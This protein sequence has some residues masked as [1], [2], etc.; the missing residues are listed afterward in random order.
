MKSKLE[1]NDIA[2]IVADCYGHPDI[3]AWDYGQQKAVEAGDGLLTF[4]LEELKDA[5][6]CKDVVSALSE[7]IRLTETV[8][9]DVMAF[10][11]HLVAYAMTTLLAQYAEWFIS[12]RRP[13]DTFGSSLVF[14]TPTLQ[15]PIETAY[16]ASLQPTL[17]AVMD[18]FKGSPAEE[19]P[20]L[21]LAKLKARLTLGESLPAGAPTNPLYAKCLSLT[22]TDVRSGSCP[23]EGQPPRQ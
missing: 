9:E 12:L 7:M 22:A 19:V 2:A 18:Q 11:R 8:S 16:G 20:Q 13:A 1:V 23:P 4:L 14:W 17:E 3:D 15:G 10:R 5:H 6:H 21:V